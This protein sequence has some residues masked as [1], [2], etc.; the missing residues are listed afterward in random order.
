MVTKIV[1]RQEETKAIGAIV[2][3]AVQHNAQISNAD[4]VPLLPSITQGTAS[5]QRV[6]DKIAPV[7]LRVNGATSLNDY[8]QGFIGQPLTVRV[9]VLAA[10]SIKDGTL[11]AS[12][13]PM[14]QLL[15]NGG[16]SAAWDG[17][18]ARS[19]FRINT[20][21][22]QVLGSRTFKLGDT[23]AENTRSMTKRWA[24]N[25]KCPKSLLYTTGNINPSN[26]APFLAVG[27]C[28]DDGVTPGITELSIVNTA[29][30]LLTF[31]DA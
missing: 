11:L 9:M 6:G 31:K 18:T 17:S 26:F 19:L 10:K 14:N 16:S 23:T 8:G 5:S 30:T 4:I 2:E 13:A 3:N 25:V 24:F 20:D 29:N 7:N 21:L 27:W 22:F 28:R 15:D 1:K 12:Q